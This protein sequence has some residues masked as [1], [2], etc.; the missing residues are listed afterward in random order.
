MD[1]KKIKAP[2]TTVTR[3]VAE[4]EK[5]TGNIYEAIAVLSKRANQISQQI[6]EA[7]N[8]KLDEFSSSTDILV[9]TFD[10]PEQT[11]VSK[12]FEQLPKPTSVATEEWLKGKIYYRRNNK[13]NTN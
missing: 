5:P 8:K 10:N 3:D 12:Y 13:K 6:K 1:Y 7:L 4:I 11:E 9:E 2:K